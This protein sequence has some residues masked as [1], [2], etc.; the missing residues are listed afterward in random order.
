MAVT[1]SE[2]GASLPKKPTAP[3]S[4][5]RLSLG[6]PRPYGK[7][8]RADPLSRTVPILPLRAC[9]PLGVVTSSRTGIFAVAGMLLILLSKSSYAFPHVRQMA[10]FHVYHPAYARCGKAKRS[11]VD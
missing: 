8:L 3:L 10:N 7:S 9:A 1:S 4:M 6:F 2:A 11:S 5:A